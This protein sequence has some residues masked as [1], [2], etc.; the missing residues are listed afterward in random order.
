MARWFSWGP[1]LS[2]KGRKF[3]GLRGWAG[4]PTHPPLTDVPITCYMLAMGFDLISWAQ[5][6]GAAGES[7]F[8]A[9][10]YVLVP[11]YVVGLLAAL[12]GFWD[13]LKSTP[14][15]SQVWRT[16][17]AHM[18]VM[19][20]T[21]AV[22]LVN[23]IV[24]WGEPGPTETLPFVLSLLAGGL[25]TIGS[26]YGGS[27]VYDYGFNVENATDLPQYHPDERDIYARDKAGGSTG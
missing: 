22:V 10:T 16:A 21:Q 13:W 17:N 20:T 27:L 7:F 24:R 3:K 9:A 15:H 23:L 14:N 19:A 8:D 6:E 5:G 12:T 2:Y 25:V 4:K 1:A 11:G 18:A 26:F